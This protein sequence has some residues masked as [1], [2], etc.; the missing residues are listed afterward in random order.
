MTEALKLKTLSTSYD[1]ISKYIENEKLRKFLAFQSLYVGISPYHG[2]NI[3]TLIPAISQ[4]HGIFHIKGGM[5]SYIK[6]LEKIIFE[7]GG[8]IK[9]N[10]SAEEIIISD[11]KAVGIRTRDGIDKGDIIIS[12]AD[13][14]YT[15]KN[16]IKEKE[17]KGKYT[18]EKLSDMK[19]S[20][21]TFMIYLGLK[22]RYSDLLVHNMYLGDDFKEN[23]NGAFIGK[24]PDKPSLY[25]YCPSRIDETMA[26]DNKESLNITVRVPN[27][28]FNNI[29]W[30]NST[31]LNLRNKVFNELRKIKGLED[32]EE[33]ILYENYLTPED[34]LVSYNSYGGTAFG[35]SPTLTQTNYF[36]PHFKLDNVDNLYFVGS[37]V[38]PGSGVSLVLLSSKHVSEEIIKNM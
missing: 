1:F 3:Y 32:I 11:G 26:K 2:P 30:D 24:L 19:Y 20:C 21:S 15:M 18:D 9:T 23:I 31:I 13:F 10:V 4:I 36:R 38:H 7:L 34:L 29:K 17:A 25:I 28:L 22:K 27:L 16:L 33:N 37:S 5:Y 6:A 35:L 8:N 12:N 14:P